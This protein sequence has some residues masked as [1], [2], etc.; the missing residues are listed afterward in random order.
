MLLLLPTSTNKLLA[1]HK[2]PYTVVRK[3]GPVT[4]EVHQPDKRKAHQTYHVNLLKEWKEP[5]KKTREVTDGEEG[6]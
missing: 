6:G 2:G 1:K 3:M 4:Y 5:A